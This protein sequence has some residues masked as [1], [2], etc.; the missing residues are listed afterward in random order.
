M[1]MF[2]I[3]CNLCGAPAL[4]EYAT[5]GVNDWMQNVVFYFPDGNAWRGK[6]DGYGR[7][8]V[9]EAKLSWPEAY[10]FDR[11]NSPDVRHQACEDACL[12]SLIS[13]EP[14]LPFNSV[15]EKKFI[16]SSANAEDQGYFF[17]KGLYSFEKPH[18][19]RHV[20]TMREELKRRRESL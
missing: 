12:G 5:D 2:S 15:V 8:I 19:C 13:L 20:L 16:V 9:G 18:Y 10:G 4:S 17:Q 14:Q 7:I 1:G 6:Y 11:E 3:K